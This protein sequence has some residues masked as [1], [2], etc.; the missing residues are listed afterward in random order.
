MIIDNIKNSKLYENS[1]EGFKEGFEFIDAYLKNP[2]EN[3]KYEISGGVYATVMD[4]TLKDEGKFE[5]HKKYIDIQFIIDGKEEMG[6]TPVNNLAI[7]EDKTPSGSDAIFYANTENKSLLKLCAGDFVVFFP[8]D[9]HEPCRKCE[10]LVSSKKI[11]V[12]VPVVK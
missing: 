10:G 5:T 8:D 12:K 6:Y 9:G 2:L 7:V 11:V 4:C 1:Y 3:G